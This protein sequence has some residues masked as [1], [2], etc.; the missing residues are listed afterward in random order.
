MHR[1]RALEKWLFLF[2]FGSFFGLSAQDFERPEYLNIRQRSPFASTF[3]DVDGDGD[4]DMVTASNDFYDTPGIAWIETLSG[5]FRYHI[6]EPVLNG[7]PSLVFHDVDADGDEDI[8]IGEGAAPYSQISWYENQDG[9]FSGRQILLDGLAGIRGFNFADLDGDGDTDLLLADYDEGALGWRERMNGT[10]TFGSQNLIA[11]Q[12]DNPTVVFAFDPNGDGE[13]DPVVKLGNRYD[14]FPNLGQGSSFGPQQLLGGAS[15]SYHIRSF[16]FD[17]D[18]DED[19]CA[20]SIGANGSFE[21]V[22]LFENINNG[23]TITR[24]TISGL[25]GAAG[26]AVADIDMDGFPDVIAS[27]RTNGNTYWYRNED[28]SGDFTAGVLLDTHTNNSLVVSTADFDGDGLP[29][30]LT[31]GSEGARLLL[32]E[33]NAQFAVRQL[34]GRVTALKAMDAGD[35]NGDQLSDLLLV[36]NSEPE[37]NWFFNSGDAYPFLEIN[38]LN[39]WARPTDAFLTD[40]DQDGGLDIIIGRDITLGAVFNEDGLGG[41]NTLAE[42]TADVDGPPAIGKADLNGDGF[43]DVLHYE[44][45]QHNTGW[46]ENVNGEDFFHDQLAFYY[47]PG[48]T[49]LMGV[50]VDQD[51]DEDPVITSSA[52]IDWAP[53]LDGQGTFD[54]DNPI[55]IDNRAPGTD[56][57]AALLNDDTRPDLVVAYKSLNQVVAYINGANPAFTPILLTDQLDR[58]QSVAAADLDGDGDQDILAGGYSDIFWFENLDGNGNFGPVQLV[59]SDVAR[60]IFRI[61]ATDLDGDGLPEVCFA[62]QEDDQLGYLQNRGAGFRVW[63]LC[64]Y[65]LNEDG[66]RDP[67]EPTLP[68]QRL[69]LFPAGSITFTDEQGGFQYI[70]AEGSYQLAYPGNPDWVATGPGEYNLEFPAGQGAFIEIGLAPATASAR[71]APA[72][73]TGFSRCSTPAPLWLSLKNEGSMVGNGVVNF[74]PDPNV[75]FLEAVPPPDSTAAGAY[76]WTFLAMAPGQTQQVEL[77]VLIPDEQ[78]TGDTLQYSA[79]SWFQ[80]PGGA[81]VAGRA[82]S[83]RTVVRCAY[84]PNDKLVEPNRGAPRFEILEGEALEYTIR[85]QN[86]GNDTAFQVSI[87]DQ[88]DS[89]LGLSTFEPVAASHSYRVYLETDGT[90]RFEFPNINLPDSACCWAASQGYVRYRI[91]PQAGALF[92]SIIENTAEIYFDANAPIVTNTTQNTLVEELTQISSLNTTGIDVRIFPNP[93]RR[94]L[95][96]QSDIPLGA[97]TYQLSVLNAEGREVYSR[98]LPRGKA[99]HVHIKQD[100]LPPGLLLVRIRDTESGTPVVVQKVVRLGND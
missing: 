97:G 44:T 19:Y 23:E 27:S 52:G 37:I 65:D 12:L 58:A 53:N 64:Y 20:T 80:A 15:G 22:Y 11:T 60:D 83:Y 59:A 84:D 63:G 31:S 89:Q 29:D 36:G 72:I 33:G 6:I 42:L 94:G 9:Q 2:A 87:E 48:V 75:E 99:L 93:F 43:P 57:T 81:L 17:L 56:F 50:D 90:L 3:T 35:L 18:G 7:F 21:R 74:V 91:Q 40:I 8:A 54:N 16:D 38:G 34:T 5:G 39:D 41:F 26:L 76:Y 79:G 24:T 28:G 82:A 70:V 49:A 71:V 95:Y 85:F 4:L 47:E 86:T 45:F 51:G 66:S 10:L 25:L 14:W 62:G 78:S 32:N 68:G 61:L 77:L 13:P 98:L 69:A 73:Q 46:S 92:G 55:Q 88:L 30:L 100:E 1:Q 67:G 96:L